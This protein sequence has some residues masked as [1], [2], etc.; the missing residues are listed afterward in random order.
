MRGPF[1]NGT[2]VNPVPPSEWSWERQQLVRGQRYRVIRPFVDGNGDPHVVGDEWVF[3]HAMFSKFDDLLTL[4]IWRASGG[5]WTVP[6]FWK[7]D[8]QEEI[9]KHFDDYVMRI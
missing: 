4:C 5:E 7:K 6:L 9:V 2:H 1:K 8:R 3:V